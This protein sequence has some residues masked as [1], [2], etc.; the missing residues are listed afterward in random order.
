MKLCHRLLS[1]FVIVAFLATVVACKKANRTTDKPVVIKSTWEVD[2]KSTYT[3]DE[4]VV[5][6]FKNITEQEVVV[7]DPLIVV[8]EQKLKTKT[9]GKEWKRMRWLY[10]PCGAS[11]PPPPHQLEITKGDVKTFV[12]NKEERWC[13]GAMKTKTLKASKGTYRLQLRYQDPTTKVVETYY[14]EFN[15]E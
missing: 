1:L 11:C 10:C 6:R 4:K 5:I 3:A 8:V 2:A 15:I 12:W 13:E 7:F 14:Q 9:E